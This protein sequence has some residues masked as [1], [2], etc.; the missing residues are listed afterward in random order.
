MPTLEKLLR[1]DSCLLSTHTG[2][3]RLQISHQL[4]IALQQAALSQMS[5]NYVPEIR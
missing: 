4:L 5:G 2:L 3:S 1:K